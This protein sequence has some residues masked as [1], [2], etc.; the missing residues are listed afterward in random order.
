MKFEFH[1][2]TVSWS[3]APA[4]KKK[5]S[6]R[7]NSWSRLTIVISSLVNSQVTCQVTVTANTQQTKWSQSAGFFLN[8]LFLHCHK[9]GSFIHASAH[10]FKLQTRSKTIPLLQYSIFSRGIVRFL[11]APCPPRYLSNLWYAHNIC[12]TALS[13]KLNSYDGGLGAG[14]GP[15]PKKMNTLRRKKVARSISTLESCWD[16]CCVTPAL[17]DQL[18]GLCNVCALAD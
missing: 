13:A 16:E 6:C 7:Y 18:R 15:Q 12:S 8:P 5:K 1:T 3:T 17:Y 4:G 2:P 11:F 10:F 9:C 14:A